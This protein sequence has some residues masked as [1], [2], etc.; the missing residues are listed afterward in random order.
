MKSLRAALA[1]VCLVGLG[2]TGAEPQY[3]LLMDDAGLVSVYSLKSDEP[4]P[5]EMTITLFQ[6][7]FF[8]TVILKSVSPVYDPYP[9][10]AGSLASGLSFRSESMAGLELQFAF[11]KQAK[12][13]G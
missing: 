1:L 8:G 11:D 13:V 3:G 4:P 7:P 12:D 5:R 6:E 9:K 10:Y 2:L